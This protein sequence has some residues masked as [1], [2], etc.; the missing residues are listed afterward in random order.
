MKRYIYILFVSVLLVSCADQLDFEPKDNQ[1]L[2]EDALQTPEDYEALLNSC[3][4]VLA[5]TFN[6]TSQ[7]LSF[8]MGDNAALP[9]ANEDLTE[10]Y[11]FNTLFFN[12]TIDGYFKQPYIAIRRCNTLISTLTPEAS[13]EIGFDATQAEVL[14]AEARF[15]RALCYFDLVRK[16]AHPWN[17]TA[18]NS[19]LGVVLRTEPNADILPRA[20]VAEVYSFLLTEL[21]ELTTDLPLQDASN[22]NKYAAHALL[23]KVYFYQNDFTNAASHASEVINSGMYA[24]DSNSRFSE[25]VSSEGIFTI[26]STD[27]DRRSGEYQGL[28][29]TAAQPAL[30]LSKETYLLLQESEFDTRINDVVV[31]NEGQPNELIGLSKFNGTFFTIPVLHLTDMLLI[32]AESLAETGDVSTAISDLN[33]IKERAYGGN[34]DELI[35]PSAGPITVITQARLERRLE[36]LG[37]GEHVF[38]VKRIGAKGEPSEVRDVNWDCPGMLLQFPADEQTQVFE[39][40]PS[41]GSC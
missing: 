34:L 26:V 38:D 31:I 39:M 19:H 13:A 9:N 24:L 33:Q 37:E 41:G 27:I 36:K 32:R 5:N 21:N 40:N 15:I 14:V 11:N 8:V 12:G 35:S 20:T 17:Y 7:K 3:Y 28:F 6:G 25:D 2:I 18:D 16:F 1:I 29:N 4:D 30:S 10:A 22:A 23:A